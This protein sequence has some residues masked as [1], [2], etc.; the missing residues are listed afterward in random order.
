MKICQKLKGKEPLSFQE[1]KKRPPVIDR[2]A[3]LIEGS[4]SD[5]IE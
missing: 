5:V 2:D 3:L 4:D 1:P